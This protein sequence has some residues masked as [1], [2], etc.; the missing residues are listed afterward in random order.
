MERKNDEEGQTD[1]NI[2]LM[3]DKN[4]EKPPRE[5]EPGRARSGAESVPMAVVQF[6]ALPA[7]ESIAMTRALLQL[8]MRCARRLAILP[9]D[10]V[11][12]WSAELAT[13]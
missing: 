1:E 9:M 4:D 2:S 5:V 7:G 13:M 8:P 6:A 11:G 3:A 10:I 12:L